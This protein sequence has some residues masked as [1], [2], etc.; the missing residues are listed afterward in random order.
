[1]RSNSLSSDVT[2]DLTT[3]DISISSD[4]TTDLTTSDIDPINAFKNDEFNLSLEDTGRITY[5][6]AAF[7]KKYEVNEKCDVIKV[8]SEKKLEA[9]KLREKSILRQMN[10]H[11]KV[12]TDAARDYFHLENLL[13]DLRKK[14]KLAKDSVEMLK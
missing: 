4:L 2:I 3:T 14:I 5:D 9:F 7:K 10:H 13:P 1:M 8:N 12:W 6:I 11:N